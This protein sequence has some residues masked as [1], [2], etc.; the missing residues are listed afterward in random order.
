M[1]SIIMKSMH[2]TKQRNEQNKE[3]EGMGQQYKH[4]LY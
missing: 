4:F 2:Q 1:S 3:S